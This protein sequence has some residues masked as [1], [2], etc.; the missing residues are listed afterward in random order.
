[1]YPMLSMVDWTER[2]REGKDFMCVSLYGQ[3]FLIIITLASPAFGWRKNLN[4]IKEIFHFA[5][6]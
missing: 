5:R 1:M 4:F 3:Q 6:T 2:E